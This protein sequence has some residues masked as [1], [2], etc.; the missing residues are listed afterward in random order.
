MVEA[1]VRLRTESRREG[2]MNVQTD[3]KE[4][5]RGGD[6]MNV[7]ERVTKMRWR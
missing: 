7:N 5:E 4:G 3:V 2:E 1:K 6:R